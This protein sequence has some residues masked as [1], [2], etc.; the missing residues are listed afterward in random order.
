[1]NSGI[2]RG[3]EALP[4]WLQKKSTWN[5]DPEVL[6]S[7]KCHSVSLPSA[8]LTLES[9]F[10]GIGQWL[11][12]QCHKLCVEVE[13]GLDEFNAC[14][15]SENDIQA[16]TC[17]KKDQATVRIDCFKLLLGCGPC[18]PTAFKKLFPSSPI[19]FQSSI[20]MLEIGFHARIDA[21]QHSNLLHLFRFTAL[22][23]RIWS[24]LVATMVLF[25]F[26]ARKISLHLFRHWALLPNPTR[27]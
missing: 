12:S 7:R 25:G 10:E 26:A 17:L 23:A 3:I 21:P 5:I 27:E 15:S 13:T 6:G 24:L 14:L 4:D 9:N 11:T 1:M 2:G 18:T 19:Q 8:Y 22:S 20:N 16:V